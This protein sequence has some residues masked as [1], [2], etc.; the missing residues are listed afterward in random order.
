MNGYSYLEDTQELKL[1]SFRNFYRALAEVKLESFQNSIKLNDFIKPTEIVELNNIIN[2]QLAEKSISEY[3]LVHYLIAV[4]NTPSAYQAN[5]LKWAI[6]NTQCIELLDSKEHATTVA[7]LCMRFR[8]ASTKREYHWLYNFLPALPIEWK[9]LYEFLNLAET[10]NKKLLERSTPNL[11]TKQIGQLADIRVIYTYAHTQ[12]DRQKRHRESRPSTQ[13]TLQTDVRKASKIT[14]DDEITYQT[15]FERCEAKLPIEETMQETVED[16]NFEFNA[17]EQHSITAQ[18]NNL[19]NRVLHKYKNELMNKPNPRVFDL[20][21]A[22]YIMG[23]LFE[24]AENSPIH[25]LLLFS[26]LSFTHYEELLVFRTRFLLSSKSKEIR[27]SHENCFFRQ[28]IDSS[29]FKDTFLKEYML[30]IGNSFTIPLPKVYLTQIL[31]L[32][33]WD[34]ADISSEVQEYIRRINND[35]TFPLTTQ[36]LPRLISDITLNELGYELESKLFAGENVNNY[37]PCHYFST[38]IIDILDIYIQ[39]LNLVGPQLDTGYID[40]FKSPI[41]FGSQQVPDL[42]F[43]QSFFYQ[44]D[45]QVRNNPN[46]F[47]TLNHY[48]IWLW[49]ICMLTTSAR[50]S[51]SFPPN[52]DYIDLDNQLMAVADKEQRYSGTIG[53]YLPF[54]NFLRDEIQHYL[55]YLKHFLHLTKAYLSQEQVQAIQEV[56]DGEHLLLLFYDSKGYVRNLE[57]SDIQK[58]CTEI[59][60]QRNWTRHFARYFF[61]QYCNEDLINGIFGHDEAMQELF[62]RYSGFKTIDYDQ[63]RAAQDKL[64][65]ILALKSMSTFTGMTIA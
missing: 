37:T 64:V 62:D 16:H 56:F 44:L 2:Q 6:F 20:P 13:E 52:L 53:R 36:N 65:E 59:A 42:P 48:S 41:T 58:Y 23:I 11:T 14:L 33:K 40:E 4:I 9:D 54:N 49:H 34:K 17:L 30:N 10:E 35:L 43:V 38:K 8:L 60:L 55:K 31:Q 51:E 50:P 21:T 24:Q 22:R 3:P 57:L 47:Q 15:H 5:A 27:F 26:A 32:K 46:P 29:K 18:I 12:A 39:T 25:A 63:I 28:S 1:E 61:A 19:K 7:N 45:H